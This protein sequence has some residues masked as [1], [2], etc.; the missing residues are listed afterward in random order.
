MTLAFR[1]RPEALEA[2][3]TW[4]EILRVNPGARAGLRRCHD[5]TEIFFQPAFHELRKRLG[6]G[7][8]G[9][10]RE[11]HGLAAVAA[12]AANVDFASISTPIAMQMAGRPPESKAVS[13]LRFRRLLQCQSH[14]E[15]FPLLLRAIKI[16]DR[17][18]NLGS[19]I[20]GTFHW[21][22]RIRQTWAMDYYSALQ[23]QDSK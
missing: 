13:E 9:S 7:H 23:V 4:W 15:L 6:L 10:S 17:S 5:L 11:G 2:V 20:E 18:V 12:L 21:D 14:A 19:L 8:E 16:L 1:N 3:K 22:D